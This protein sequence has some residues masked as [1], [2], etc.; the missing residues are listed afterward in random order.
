M[1]YGLFQVREADEAAIELLKDFI[2]E[3]VFDAHAHLYVADTVPRVAGTAA[4]P[5]A[6]SMPEDYVNH[7]KPFLPNAKEIGANFF[8]MPDP[9]MVDRA[10][11]RRAN[12]HVF[13]MV[14]GKSLHTVSPYVTMTD[15][16]ETIGELVSRPEAVAIKCYSYG[17]DVPKHGDL[18]IHEF[19]PEA[20]WVVSAQTGKPIILH[21][22]K[23]RA[24]AHPENLAYIQ[25]MC[26]KYPEA[27]L[28]LAHCA[29]GFAAWTAVDSIRKLAGLDNIW[30]DFA[31]V[32]EAAPMAACIMATGGKRVLWGSDY[33]ICM[34]RGRAVSW[35][36]GQLWLVD[37][38]VE[39]NDGCLLAAEN[40]LATRQACNLLDLDATQVQDLFY[41][42]AARLFRRE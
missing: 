5:Q 30:Y 25:T 24:L 40:L 37:D 34:H 13:D 6:F 9:A 12:D 14:R 36:L 21:M 7:M 10:V 39:D 17:A 38:M 11:L 23:D 19:L 42:N 3:K 27:Q 41:N 1:D 26:R 28:I 16:E 2:P 4:F 29:R 20:A 32:C 18:G 35:G 15:T 22:M 8:T 31:A 33:P